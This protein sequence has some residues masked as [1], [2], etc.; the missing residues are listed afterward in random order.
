MEIKVLSMARP[1]KPVKALK[2]DNIRICLTQEEG[3]LLRAIAENAG[4]SVSGWARNAVL[5]SMAQA[6]I[7]PT[8]PVVQA[9]TVS[10]FQ[11]HT[12]WDRNC[13]ENT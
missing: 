7:T 4:Q 13:Q 12:Q 10:S 5:S 6:P 2:S 11:P 9:P 3:E 8:A 1:K